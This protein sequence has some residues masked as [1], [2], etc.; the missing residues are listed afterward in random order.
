MQGKRESE[1]NLEE[2]ERKVEFWLVGIVVHEE[3]GRS[4]ASWKGG[5]VL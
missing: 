3:E 2:R 5:M 1:E 4:R